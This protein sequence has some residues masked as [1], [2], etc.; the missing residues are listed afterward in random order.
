MQGDE[1][2]KILKLFEGNEEAKA[3]WWSQE[4]EGLSPRDGDTCA[5][6]ERKKRC[7]FSETS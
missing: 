7:T 2:V 1:E 4:I 3:G 5:N 6:K